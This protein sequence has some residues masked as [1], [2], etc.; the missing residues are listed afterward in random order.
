MQFTCESARIVLYLKNYE[1]NKSAKSSRL[2]ICTSGFQC[3]LYEYIHSEV[4][5]A[6]LRMVSVIVLARSKG[7]AYLREHEQLKGRSFGQGRRTPVLPRS[8]RSTISKPNGIPVCSD[9][10]VS[11]SFSLHLSQ[12]PSRSTGFY[13]LLGTCGVQLQRVATLLLWTARCWRSGHLLEVEAARRGSLYWR[14]W[15]L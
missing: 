9:L 2:I 6:V 11:F 8:V 13:Q 7:A 14:L 4:I 1:W 12:P 3:R 5:L 10:K 15:L